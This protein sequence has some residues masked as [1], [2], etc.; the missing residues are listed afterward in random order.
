MIF[1]AFIVGFVLGGLAGAMFVYAYELKVL[2]DFRKRVEIIEQKYKEWEEALTHGKDT[3]D[4]SLVQ[5]VCVFL[6]F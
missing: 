5:S 3:G 2:R 1:L 6:R 4:K